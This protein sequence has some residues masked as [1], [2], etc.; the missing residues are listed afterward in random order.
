MHTL[1]KKTDQAS[2]KALT[3]RTQG[4]GVTVGLVFKSCLTAAAEMNK[5]P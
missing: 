4:S 3:K 5:K 1:Q 2:R